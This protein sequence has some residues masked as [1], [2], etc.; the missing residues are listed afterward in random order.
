MT[1]AYLYLREM[2]SSKFRKRF[3]VREKIN[4]C[5]SLI[6]VSYVIFFSVVSFISNKEIISLVIGILKLING[7]F[8]IYVLTL[9]NDRVENL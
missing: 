7:L 3:S 2:I 4:L 5:L 8:I 9:H 1:L 6:G